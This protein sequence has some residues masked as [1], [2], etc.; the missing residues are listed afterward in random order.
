M[1]I[2]YLQKINSLPTVAK[3]QEACGEEKFIHGWNCSFESNI[4]KNRVDSFMAE[5]NEF[6]KRL[7]DLEINNKALFSQLQKM[8]N[9]LN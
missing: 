2:F 9:S 1:I 6:K 7:E 8:Q 5:K 4:E 3:L